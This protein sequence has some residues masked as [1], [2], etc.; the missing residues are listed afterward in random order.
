MTHFAYKSSEEIFDEIRRFTTPAPGTTCAAPATSGC[1]KRRCS[2][3]CRPDDAPDRHPIRYL[4]DGVSQ[5]LFVDDDGRRPRLAFPHRR[6]GRCSIRA[7]TWMPAELP[8]DDY[9]MVLNTGRLQHQWHTMT[10]TGRVDKLNKLNSGPFVEIH[11]DD[12]ARPGITDGQPVELTSRRGRAVLPAVVTDRVRPGNCFGAVPLER[13]TRRV[14]DHQRADQRRRRPGFAAAGVQGV[15][16]SCDR[17]P[18]ES[19]DADPGTARRGL[20][21]PAP[22][23]GRRRK[24]LSQQA[25]SPVIAGGGR[26]AG[27]AVVGAGA[28]RR[29]AVGGRHA[30]RAVLAG[31][32]AAATGAASPSDRSAGAVGVADRQRRGVRGAGGRPARPVRGW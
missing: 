20:A 18:V 16:G 7:R 4:N 25:S 12:A 13:R 19:P 27:A 3:P 10:K 5:D 14:P 17:A 11:P 15:R 2:G 8:D 26:C 28:R 9:P 30:G 24:A 21:S 1:A 6:A 29:P 22:G 23:A 32:R 31:R